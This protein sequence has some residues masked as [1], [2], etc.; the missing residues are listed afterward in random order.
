MGFGRQQ[1]RVENSGAKDAYSGVRFDRHHAVSSAYLETFVLKRC[2][3]AFAQTPRWWVH[4]PNE[5]FS[6]PL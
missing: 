4:T 3:P 1:L 5:G 2:S 6:I